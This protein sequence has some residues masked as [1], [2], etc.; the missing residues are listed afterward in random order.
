VPDTT[1]SLTERLRIYSKPPSPD[2]RLKSEAA[3]GN[4]TV[5]HNNTRHAKEENLKQNM[6]TDRETKPNVK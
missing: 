4:I 3:L 5:M 1:S 2:H 6:T